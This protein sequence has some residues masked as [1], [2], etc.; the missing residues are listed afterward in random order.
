LTTPLAKATS[1]NVPPPMEAV[2]GG[3]GKERSHPREKRNK[4]TE[5]NMAG[6]PM[7]AVQLAVTADADAMLMPDANDGADALMNG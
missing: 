4:G 3:T 7:P 2:N 5:L 1:T 6:I